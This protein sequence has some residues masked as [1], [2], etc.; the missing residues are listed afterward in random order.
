MSAGCWSK[1]LLDV[2]ATGDISFPDVGEGKT[3]FDLN[4][5][6]I[7]ALPAIGDQQAALLGAGVKEGVLSFNTGTGGQVSIALKDIP[8]LSEVVNDVQVRPYFGL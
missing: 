7:T 8:P 1:A 2:C 5:T 4:C 3:E 6:H